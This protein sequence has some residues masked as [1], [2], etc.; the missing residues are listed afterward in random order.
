VTG[1]TEIPV[2]HGVAVT[3]VE[4]TQEMKNATAGVVGGADVLV[5]AAAPADYRPL[6]FSAEKRPRA[7]GPI[8]IG[9]EPTEDILAGTIEKRRKGMIAVGFALES[10]DG[11]ERARVKLGRKGLDMIV[12]NR[13]GVE[14][15]GFETETNQVSFITERSLVTL[16]LMP[17]REVAERLLD[18]VERLL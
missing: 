11:T 12:L 15:A 18:E 10:G 2:P 1:P 3:K 5:M 6:S 16:P 7:A 9:L 17:K 4:T 14:G 13:V 8:E